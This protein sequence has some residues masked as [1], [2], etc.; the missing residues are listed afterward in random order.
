MYQFILIRVEICSN[1]IAHKMESTSTTFLLSLVVDIIG[2]QLILASYCY[3]LLMSMY[4]PRLPPIYFHIKREKSRRQISAIKRPYL[5]EFGIRKFSRHKQHRQHRQCNL[6]SRLQ[7]S[8]SIEHHS[9]RDYVM[10][11]WTN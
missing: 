3:I 7:R 1:W 6:Y 2:R 5:S 10:N 11:I 4:Y 8:Y 9:E